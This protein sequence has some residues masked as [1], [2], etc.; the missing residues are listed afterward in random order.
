[1]LGQSA[2]KVLKLDIP[3]FENAPGVRTYMVSVMALLL[4]AIRIGEVRSVYSMDQAMA[5]RYDL[6]SQGK[7]LAELLPEMDKKCLDLSQ[8]WS[9][10]EAFDFIGAGFDYAA[11]WYGHAKIFEATGKYS[12]HVDSEEWLHL[13]FFMRNINKIGTF[14]FANSENPALS[15]DIEVAEF[16]VRLK[17]PFAIVYDGDEKDFHVAAEYIK[18]PKT[19]YPISIPL[20]QFAPLAIISGYIAAMI[21]EEYG[22]GCINEWEFCKGGMAVNSSRI[23]I[24]E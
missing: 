3:K 22:R 12:M 2:Q 18:T 1:M 9:G 16:C 13:N 19:E 10:M 5:Y 7:K 21:G 4:M 15:R 8:K 24:K 14:M 11:A 23:I 20:T 6:C 17:R